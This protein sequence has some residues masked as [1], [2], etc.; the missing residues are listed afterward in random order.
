M[1]LG[2]GPRDLEGLHHQRGP[3]SS[4]AT[5]AARA[6]PPLVPLAAQIADLSQ[7]LSAC[8]AR[9]G[10]VAEGAAAAF[11]K[12][13]LGRLGTGK[14]KS[15]DQLAAEMEKGS[16]KLMLK[17]DAL[18]AC[19]PVR[20]VDSVLLRLFSVKEGGKLLVETATSYPDGRKF[21]TFRLPGTKRER[22]ESPKDVVRRMRDMLVQSANIHMKFDYDKVDSYSEEKDS[23]TF[24][25][26]RTLYRI[27]VVEGYVS[28]VD[29]ELRKTLALDE[30]GGMFARVTAKGD[31]KEFAW[32]TEEE[33]VDKQVKLRGDGL[34]R[35]GVP[36]LTPIS[37]VKSQMT[38]TLSQRVMEV[39]RKVDQIFR[40]KALL[41]LES[42]LQAMETWLY[43]DPSGAESLL[44]QE[45]AK[46]RYI[47]QHANHLRDFNR[48]LAEINRMEPCINPLSLQELP[49]CDDRLR[50]L[51]ARNAVA[52]NSVMRLHTHVSQVAE[53]YHKAM[54]AVNEQMMRWNTLLSK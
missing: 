49:S 53:E 3:N 33:A 41:E 47:L 35:H 8:E 16:A 2:P 48:V 42:R 32:L 24:P 11:G 13:D 40:D 25:G 7:R 4:V 38:G 6:A 51:E 52:V 28:S 29:L 34:G 26:L 17:E 15:V 12:L 27:E 5:A 39:H 9:L 45:R 54:V 31:K 22:N 37:A 23:E 43:I 21:E 20:V 10:V 14:A 50:R 30:G 46:R 18:G 1:A 36:I 19:T 44:Q